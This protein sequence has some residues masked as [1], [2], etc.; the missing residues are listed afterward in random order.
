MFVLLSFGPVKFGQEHLPR[1]LSSTI[2][3]SFFFVYWF[4]FVFTLKKIGRHLAC[5]LLGIT[6]AREI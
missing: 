5:V 3:F 6:D 4:C 2:F 1:H